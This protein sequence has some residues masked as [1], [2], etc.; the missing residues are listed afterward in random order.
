M[1]KQEFLILSVDST[2]GFYDFFCGC[3]LLKQGQNVFNVGMICP[4]HSLVTN[5]AHFH[6]MVQSKIDNGIKPT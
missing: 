5:S 4:K 1:D 2:D 6:T 3:R